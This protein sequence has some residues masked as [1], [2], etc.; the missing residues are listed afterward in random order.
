[1]NS[2]NTTP[3][4]LRVDPPVAQGGSAT[5]DRPCEVG[6]MS[7]Q[8]T[9]GSGP[10]L[11]SP[12]SGHILILGLGIS[13]MSM[14]R[15]CVRL[16]ATVTVLDTRATPPALA[17]LQSELP[18]VTFQHGTFTA[19]IIDGTDIRA[20]F[21]SPGL[22]PDAVSSLVNAAK[23][24]ALWVGNELTLFNHA[25]RELKT[26]QGYDPKILAVTGTNGKTT[27]TSLTG[28]LVERA[29]KSVA[30]AGNIGPALLDT[31]A[32]HLDAGT[33]PQ[34]WSLELSS[35]QL[36]SVDD[37]MP[38]AAT[39]LNI[40]ED[41]L[42]WHG[43]MAEYA[44]AKEN[45]YGF[46]SVLGKSKSLKQQTQ[47]F[48]TSGLPTQVDEYAIEV[49]AGMRWLVRAV[50]ESDEPPARV[51]KGMTAPPVP[52]VIQRLMPA[53]ALRIRGA[54]NATN[55]LAALAL[56]SRAGC[57]LAPML[58]G[59]REYR[60]EPHRVESIAIHNEVEYID[61][62]K[63]TNVGATVA[64]LTSLGFDKL[65]P[66]GVEKKIILILGGDGKGQDFAPLATP[67]HKYVKSLVL[68]GR[69]ANPIEVALRDTQV[70]LQH[71][72][73]LEVA[74]T[75]CAKLA[76]AG[77]VVLLSPACASLDMFK[78]YKHRADVFAAAVQGLADL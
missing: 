7:A 64:A 28:L 38:T 62:S 75:A 25:L 3:P 68:I 36:D 10:V 55:S 54:H 58:Y 78:D 42:D 15:W 1:M 19:D 40:T 32:Q 43:T 6:E 66:N 60:G 56:A 33:L 34:V 13:G 77:D 46:E 71:A 17:E 11:I 73:S 18:S 48:V 29:G 70:T 39:V 8:L 51:K 59:L 65:S 12:I 44:A 52:F 69:D 2:L 30:V 76:S 27:V 61:D 50:P 37:F 41:H 24:S 14:A 72:T 5:N 67:I 21:K 47:I 63:G 53:D 26:L 4:S 23:A 45:I 9:E 35:F 74:V 49:V 57:A 22:S 16:G 31:L 20:V